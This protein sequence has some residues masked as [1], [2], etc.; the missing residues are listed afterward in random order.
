MLKPYT[1]FCPTVGNGKLAGPPLPPVRTNNSPTTKPGCGGGGGGGTGGGGSTGTMLP[2]SVPTAPDRPA[3]PTPSPTIGLSCN[4]NVM[5][6]SQG[7]EQRVGRQSRALASPGQLAV[8]G[9]L[10][11]DLDGRWAV[12]G[13]V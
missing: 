12:A 9:P 10:G 7:S 13:T 11:V 2:V 8:H 6:P 4:L 3:G 5:K 1:T